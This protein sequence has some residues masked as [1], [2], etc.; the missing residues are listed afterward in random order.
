MSFLLT[1]EF[2]DCFMWNDKVFNVDMSFDNILRMYEMFDDDLI[3]EI[4][5]PFVTI[6]MLVKE[7]IKFDS[8]EQGIDLFKFLMKEFLNIDIDNSESTEQKVFDFK[9]DAEIIY[10][11]FYAEYKI[12]LFEEIGKLHWFKFLALLNNLDDESKFKRVVNIRIMNIPSP[13]ESSQEYRDH[14]VKMKEVYS[15]DERSIEE[16]TNH[17]F[18]ELAI[19]FGKDQSK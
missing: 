19:I 1:S 2:D 3:L 6:K 11:S 10:A 17:T 15:L 7:E 4:E 13:Q 12:D 16:K 14:I 5:K 18:D 9:K 8:L